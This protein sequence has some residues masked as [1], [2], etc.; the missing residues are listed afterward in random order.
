MAFDFTFP[1]PATGIAGRLDLQLRPVA[2]Y[3]H[4]VSA[5][6]ESDFRKVY[7]MPEVPSLAELFQAHFD[8]GFA[9]DT[10]PR[11]AHDLLAYHFNVVT[12]GNSLK[13]DAVQSRP[14]SFDFV[15]PD[16]LVAW[17]SQPAST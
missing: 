14:G 5:Q 7:L 4:G 17:A 2:T 8:V 12:T 10:I 3:P 9:T 6:I 15:R 11:E 13:W 1:L 16:A